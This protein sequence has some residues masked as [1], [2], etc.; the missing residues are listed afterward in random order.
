MERR[1][2]LLVTGIAIAVYAGLW[3]ILTLALIW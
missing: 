1:T 2:T 3:G